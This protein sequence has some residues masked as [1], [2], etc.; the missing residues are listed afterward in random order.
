M[1]NTVQDRFNIL[2]PDKPYVTNTDDIVLRNAGTDNC[3]MH[4]R[5]HLMEKILKGTHADFI[6]QDPVILFLNGEFW[7]MYQVVENDNK[8][9]V[10]TNYGYKSNEIDFLKETGNM[11]TTCGSDTGFF[12][13]LNYSTTANQSTTAFYN[14]MNEMFDLE[15]M[16]DYFAAETYYCNEDFIGPWTNNVVLWRPSSPIGKWKYITKDLDFGL[17]LS[18]R[19]EDNM[20]DTILHPTAASYNAQLLSNMLLNPTFKRYFINRYA[21]LINTTFLPSNM[22]PVLTAIHDSM[23]FDMPQHFAKWGNDT[24]G[25]GQ[26]NK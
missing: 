8:N 10:Q 26:R 23:A 13:M 17:G 11:E 20:L 19:F 16:T 3:Q 5:D 4:Y 18:S 14:A 25:L 2:F 7:G 15:N 21:D 6:A 1:I 22:L 24:I 12:N 9:F